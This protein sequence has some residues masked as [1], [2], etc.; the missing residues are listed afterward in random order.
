MDRES[1]FF[2]MLPYHFFAFRDVNAINFIISNKGLYPMVR[3]SHLAD[4]FAGSLGYSLQF[5]G[6][7]ITGTWK[8]SFNNKFLHNKILRI[9]NDPK[10]R[11]L[12]L[13]DDR[14]VPYFDPE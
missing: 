3:L 10:L 12:L 6:R 11:R 13:Y 9:N 8:V 14:I 5:G 1:A 4:S 2:S 7:E